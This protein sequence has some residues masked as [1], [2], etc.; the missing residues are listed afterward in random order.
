VAHTE[1]QLYARKLVRLA[2]LRAKDGAR[3]VLVQ[4]SAADTTK[5][6]LNEHI[7]WVSDLWH[8]RVVHNADIVLA[9]NV[10]G[11]HFIL[12]V[13]ST[14]RAGEVIVLFILDANSKLFKS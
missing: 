10:E 8:W 3:D 5:G 9:K 2:R 7:V 4:V 11:F 6:D 14:Y 1:R 13:D 12:I